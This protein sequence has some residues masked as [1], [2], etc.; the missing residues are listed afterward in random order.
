MLLRGKEEEEGREKKKETSS[1]ISIKGGLLTHV[2]EKFI[3][4]RHVFK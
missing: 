1:W 3:V 4:V 2:D